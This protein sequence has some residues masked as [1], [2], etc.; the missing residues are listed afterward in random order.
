MHIFNW[1]QV[2]SGSG[3]A[4]DIFVLIEEL[5]APLRCTPFD[6][7]GEVYRDQFLVG[8][9]QWQ[10]RAATSISVL[11]E[12]FY[13]AS[14]LWVHVSCL[15]FEGL[16]R[17]KKN[18][19]TRMLDEQDAGGA[20]DFRGPSGWHPWEDLAKVVSPEFLGDHVGDVLH[21][22]SS[23]SIW[24]LPVHATLGMFNAPLPAHAHIL[25]DNSFL[26]QVCCVSRPS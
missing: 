7:Q 20:E 15:P 22:Y 19:S 8:D 12:I 1:L 21:E 16:Y 4:R 18:N 9:G 5:V 24:K 13:G 17:I 3:N 10:R 23:D 25:K 14:G 2:L 11:N 26:Q 6:I